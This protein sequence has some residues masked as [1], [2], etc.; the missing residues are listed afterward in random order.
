MAHSDAMR[1]AL[2]AML[3]AFYSYLNTSIPIPTKSEGT[4]KKNP[5]KKNQDKR[6]FIIHT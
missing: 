4:G 1:F 5:R 3:C 6:D 2:R